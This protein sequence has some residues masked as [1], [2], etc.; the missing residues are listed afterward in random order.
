MRY[1]KEIINEIEMVGFVE[2]E[3]YW[4]RDYENPEIKKFNDLYEAVKYADWLYSLTNDDFR[5]L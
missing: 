2:I 1:E 3:I 5:I 4:N